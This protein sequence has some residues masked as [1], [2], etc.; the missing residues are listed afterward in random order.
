MELQKSVI[1]EKDFNDVFVIVVGHL[2]LADFLKSTGKKECE[3]IKNCSLA[4]LDI[5]GF[6]IC[7]SK[8]NQ[9]FYEEKE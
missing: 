1:K 8:Y 2:S 7:A 5:K 3:L 6:S 4:L 9:V